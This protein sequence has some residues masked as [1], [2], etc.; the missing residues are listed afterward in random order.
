MSTYYEIL[1]IPI[2]ASP[3]E[4]KQAYNH[5]A[6]RHHPDKPGG[7]IKIYQEAREAYETLKDP[8]RRRHYDAQISPKKET[9]P[10]RVRKGTDLKIT[11]AVTM[12]ELSAGIEKSIAVN[13]K[14]QC[15]ACHGT[16]STTKQMK[17]CPECRGLGIDMVSLVFGPE[18][19]CKQCRGY[20]IIPNEDPCPECRGTG[21]ISEAIHRKIKLCSK[22]ISNRMTLTGAGNYC[23]GGIAGDLI[24]DLNIE[25]ND[26]YAIDGLDLKR[27]I[28]ITPAQ[29][30][31]GDSLVLD[32]FTKQVIV[33]VPAGIPH[34]YIL[35]K[36]GS[37]LQGDDR[38]GDLI[39]RMHINI[40]IFVTPEE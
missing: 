5:I 28:N 18:K 6:V 12:D 4:V 23:Q 13:R 26:L 27:T 19:Y 11:I 9:K 17:Q 1:G 22:D 37:G 20:A 14:G 15:P 8:D 40:P 16:G 36:K 30:V 39:L 10:P 24:V 2:H 7:N 33:D 29:A 38:T 21:L 3:K 31:L 34:G 25:K 32:V 35:E